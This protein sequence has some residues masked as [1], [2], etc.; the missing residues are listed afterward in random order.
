MR[1]EKLYT[2]CGGGKSPCYFTYFYYKYV[3][4]CLW[5]KW[6]QTYLCFEWATRG[7]IYNDLQASR[8]WV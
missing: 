4:S 2:P 7:Q 8:F 5:S 3:F 6:K 1:V